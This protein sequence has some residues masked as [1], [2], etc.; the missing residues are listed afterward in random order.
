MR[1]A[2]AQPATRTLAALVSFALAWLQCAPPAFASTDDDHPHPHHHELGLELSADRPQHTV[3]QQATLTIL[4][5]PAELPPKRLKHLELLVRLPDPAVLALVSPLTQNPTAVVSNPLPLG[6]PVAKAELF[7]RGTQRLAERT[8]HR[9]AEADA[10][11]AELEERLAREP[12]PHKRRALQ[13][14]IAALSR[15][16]DRLA[17]KLDRLQRPLASAAL[18]L[19]VVPPDTSPPVTPQSGFIHG[20]VFE[21]GTGNP[22]AD[23]AVS[24]DGVTG[25]VSSD[26]A[27]A[28]TL[29]TPGPGVFA[30]NIQKAGYTSVQR[31][32]QVFAGRD[33]AVEPA[34]LTP[35]DSQVTMITATAGGVATDSSGMFEV[36]F[37]PGAAPADLAVT[38]TPLPEEAQLPGP[39]EDGQG[40]LAAVYFEPRFTTFNTPATM[41][42]RNTMGLPPGTQVN[43]QLWHE[44][45]QQWEDQP[46]GQV[47]ADG[48]WIE[49]QIIRFFCWYCLWLTL[50][51]PDGSKNP[52]EPTPASASSPNPAQGC[53][54]SG[55]SDVCVSSGAL[56]ESHRLPSLRTLGVS[57]TLT[58]TY[59]SSS[60]DPSVLLGTDY[61]L[62]TTGPGATLVP[63]T[64][65]AA[66]EIEGRV[67]T[68]SFQGASGA[69][70]Q[71]A[72]W[73]GRNA[74]G[75]LLPTGAYPSP[76]SSPT[77]TTPRWVAPASRPSAA[78]RW[79]QRCR[80][81]R[82]CSTSAARP[83]APAGGWKVCSGSARSPMAPSS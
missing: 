31:S 60:A 11:R 56:A 25:A 13:L 66:I 52:A 37:P 32:T 61:T 34:V 38:I 20:R 80:A 27:G 51:V 9:L 21:A 72:L 12:N 83:S 44:D 33:V 53:D 55:S 63:A 22:L 4:V 54:I 5:T 1:H 39:M 8:R 7:K 45:G 28:F 74:R 71:A 64:T 70:R 18:T 19:T 67:I 14:A 57:R 65:S 15:V 41:R 16:I 82:C 43:L 17:E 81:T 29:V 49:F 23:A 3:G 2:A 69:L 77:T 59:R 75:Q 73:D 26:A 30:L 6:T 10:A 40:H 78:R 76:W 68:A 62:S 47:T 46:A 24:A 35:I 42:A 36:A 79:P 50:I 48:A 58:F